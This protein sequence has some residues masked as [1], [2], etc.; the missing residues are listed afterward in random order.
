[1]MSTDGKESESDRLKRQI[2]KAMDELKRQVSEAHRR[3]GG[4]PADPNR[5]PGQVIE[6]EQR[7]RRKK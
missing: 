3:G 1:M 6:F 5:K 4:P 7:R 2:E